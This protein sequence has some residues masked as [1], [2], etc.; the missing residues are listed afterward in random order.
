M[1]KK[2]KMEIYNLKKELYKI[3]SKKDKN[4]KIVIN[5][6]RVCK[7]AHHLMMQITTT[8]WGY[9][10]GWIREKYPKKCLETLKIQTEHLKY[11]N[12]Y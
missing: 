2:T 6:E 7:G 12:N 1:R 4:I 10:S 9:Y 5:F 11:Y 3:L 8:K